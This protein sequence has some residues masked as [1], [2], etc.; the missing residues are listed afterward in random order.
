MYLKKERTRVY[1]HNDWV[2]DHKRH[3]VVMSFNVLGRTMRVTVYNI[4]CVIVRNSPPQVGISRDDA[5]LSMEI[6]QRG[7]VILS[8]DERLILQ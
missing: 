3:F 5:K 6:M 8:D 7:Q 4:K 2:L 1:M